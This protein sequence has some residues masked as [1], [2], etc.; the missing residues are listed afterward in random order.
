ML[1]KQ[2]ISLKPYNTFGIDVKAKYFAEIK[3]EQDLEELFMSRA[4][5]EE[6]LLILGGGSNMLFTQDFN[7]LVVKMAITGISHELNGDTFALQEQITAMTP[8]TVKDMAAQLVVET[9]FGGS[10]YRE[11]FFERVVA[12]AE[13]P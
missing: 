2:D 12:L 3:N 1:I 9:D 13:K 4:A 5:K 7:G 6:K 8:M 11:V 10:D